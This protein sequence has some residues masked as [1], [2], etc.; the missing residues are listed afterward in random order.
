MFLPFLL[1]LFSFNK[2]VYVICS[3]QQQRQTIQWYGQ[4][5]QDKIIID[6]YKNMKAGYFVELGAADGKLISNTLA[7]EESFKWKGL[8]IEPSSAYLDLLKSGRRCVK[9]SDVVSGKTAEYVFW[10][11]LGRN[12]H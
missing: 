11:K 12:Q 6:L 3:Q 2:I 10:I 1:L 4:H 8:C 7:L 5:L 9:R